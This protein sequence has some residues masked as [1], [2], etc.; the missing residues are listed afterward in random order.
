M[1]P[2]LHN[3]NNNQDYALTHVEST[4]SQNQSKPQRQKYQSCEL[5]FLRSEIIKENA[6][7]DHEFRYVIGIIC[8]HV[9][10][11]TDVTTPSMYN[12]VQLNQ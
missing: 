5:R 8:H 3:K 10:V 7:N 6:T 1:L 12:L 11:Y 9:K 2:K 4:I